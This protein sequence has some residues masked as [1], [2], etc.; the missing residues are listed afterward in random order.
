MMRF[1]P[2]DIPGVT[3]PQL[4]LKVPGVWT[5]GHEENLRWGTLSAHARPGCADM[6]DPMVSSV[7]VRAP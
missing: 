4:Y 5:G 7:A 6:R 1:C 2:G 3:L